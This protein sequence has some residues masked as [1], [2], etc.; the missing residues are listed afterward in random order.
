MDP[1]AP[2]AHRGLQGDALHVADQGRDGAE[3]QLRVLCAGDR[4]IALLEGPHD[5]EGDGPLLLRPQQAQERGVLLQAQDWSIGK[6][7]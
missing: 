3:H 7:G 1:T 6:E 5:V 2:S 4:Q